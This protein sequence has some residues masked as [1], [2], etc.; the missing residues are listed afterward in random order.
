MK[1]IEQLCIG[2]VVFLMKEEDIKVAGTSISIPVKDVAPFAI[3]A[4]RLLFIE[5]SIL[6]SRGLSLS[7]LKSPLRVTANTP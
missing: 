2:R 1:A 6:K 5:T 4:P 3:A 7:T